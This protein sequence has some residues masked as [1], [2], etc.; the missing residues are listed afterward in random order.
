MI[1][2]FLDIETTGFPIYDNKKMPNYKKTV[3][4]E[5]S[6]IL[7]ICIILYENRQIKSNFHHYIKINENIENSHIH[8]ITDEISQTKGVDIKDL[9]LDILKLLEN[10]DYIIAHN[11]IFDLSIIFSEIYKL[12]NNLSENIENI[13]K[14]K[15]FVCTMLSTI[16]LCK[17]PF[18]PNSKNYKFPKLDEL[19]FFLFSEKRLNSHNA[20]SDTNDMLKCYYELINRNL[21]I[22]SYNKLFVE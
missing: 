13:I 5:T 17:I 15:I 19:Y 21:K 14:N 7:E 9:Y 3:N 20:L 16:D 22:N 1:E 2:C 6:K 8:G 11:I 10:S 12:D 18:Y 4:F